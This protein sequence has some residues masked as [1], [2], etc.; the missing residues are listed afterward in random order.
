MLFLDEMAE[1]QTPVLQAL[2]QPIEA[3]RVTITRSGGSVTYPA[4]FTLAAATNPCPCGWAGA[5]IRTCRW[6]PP[7]VPLGCTRFSGDLLRSERDAIGVML[8]HWNYRDRGRDFRHWS[9][10]SQRLRIELT[11]R[12][13]EPHEH[14][15]HATHIKTEESYLASVARDLRWDMGGLATL[16][17]GYLDDRRL[18]EAAVLGLWGAPPYA[19]PENVMQL[20]R[21]LFRREPPNDTISFASG[22]APARLVTN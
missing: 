11:S 19:V 4:R 3:G 8:A 1:F 17:K 12:G 16:T 22:R 20:W 18:F 6:R 7:T 14:A 2:R 21:I 5:G 10:L 13:F 15:P 9:L